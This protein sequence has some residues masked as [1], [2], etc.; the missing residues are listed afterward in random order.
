MRDIVITPTA[1]EVRGEGATNAREKGKKIVVAKE[2][3]K[4][5]KKKKNE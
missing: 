3:K 2:E 1:G 4:K 5:K